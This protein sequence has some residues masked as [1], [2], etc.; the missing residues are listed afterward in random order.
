[1]IDSAFSNDMSP[2]LFY[3]RPGRTLKFQ[4]VEKVLASLG[5]SITLQNRYHLIKKKKKNYKLLDMSM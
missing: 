4:L 3:D 1:M 5:N 2:S